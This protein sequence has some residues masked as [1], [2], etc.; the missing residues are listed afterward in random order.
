MEF[1]FKIMKIMNG[2]ELYRCAS[3]KNDTKTTIKSIKTTAK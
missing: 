2:V 3:I 1:K